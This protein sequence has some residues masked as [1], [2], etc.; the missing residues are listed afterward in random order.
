MTLESYFKDW[1]K[2]IDIKELNKV[3]VTLNNLYK[4][5]TV[6]PSKNDVFKAFNLCNYY[7]CKV[8]ILGLSPYHDGSATGIAFANKQDVNEDSMSPSLK[9]I[10]NAVTDL[11]NPHNLIIFDPTLESWEKQGILLLNCSLTVEK[12]RPES[13]LALWRP[14]ISKLLS[15]MSEINTGIVYMLFGSEAETF[16]P[17]IGCNNFILK[18]K[19]PA[20]YARNNRDMPSD[21]FRSV[22]RLMKLKY[23]L[24]IKW[25]EEI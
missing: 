21:I 8:V 25:Y 12:N 1:M 13:H 22:D 7:D 3:L 10:K 11:Q 4:T 14:F 19:H 20:W 17:Y 15:N 18:E 6:F 16:E 2:V 5:H 23:N 24:T 9:V